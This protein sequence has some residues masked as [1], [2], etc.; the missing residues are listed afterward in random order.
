MEESTGRGEAVTN[1][2]LRVAHLAQPPTNYQ[3]QPINAPID[4]LFFL[5]TVTSFSSVVRV[6][7][8]QHQG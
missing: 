2:P 7:T 1:P 6:V 8:F 3:H 4:T 5:S